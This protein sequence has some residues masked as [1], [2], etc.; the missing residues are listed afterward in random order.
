[1]ELGV[2]LWTGTWGRPHRAAH[3]PGRL[4]VSET[5]RWAGEH[6]RSERHELAAN[7]A[8]ALAAPAAS[9]TRGAEHLAIAR[10]RSRPARAVVDNSAGRPML[11]RWSTGPSGRARSA[12]LR[13]G[14]KGR[15]RRSPAAP[16][17]TGHTT[18]P[19]RQWP[20][21]RCGSGPPQAGRW[22]PARRGG[23]MIRALAGADQS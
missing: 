6:R 23:S 13:A 12:L 14:A 18:R 7:I 11:A 19:C 5:K 10:A 2:S 22:P 17:A 21:T 9:P 1:M 16:A 8:P 4:H 3:E 15:G 20:A